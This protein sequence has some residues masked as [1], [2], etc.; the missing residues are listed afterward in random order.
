MALSFPNFKDPEVQPVA[1]EA[2][3]STWEARLAPRLTAVRER[4]AQAAARAGRSPGEVTLVAVSKGHP[5]AAVVAAL[6]LGV[7]DFG[8]NRVEEAEPKIEAVAA[9]LQ[10]LGHPERPRWHMIG[11]IQSRKAARAVAPYVLVHSVDRLKIARRLN[12]FAGERGRVLPILL[13]VNISGEE[14]KYGFRPDEVIPAVEEILTLPHLRIEGLMT[15]APFVP[16]P[17]RVRPV[18]AGLRDLRDRL[19]ARFPDVS[20]RHLSMG[21]SNDFEVAIEEGATLVRIGTA[22][23]GPREEA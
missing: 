14:T 9:L 13:E 7:L 22:I 8:E 1:L 3:V 2:Q 18:F 4:M 15:M 11:H 19:Q 6:R 21:M 12:R 5:A 23:F 16:D 17:E 20:W 10:A